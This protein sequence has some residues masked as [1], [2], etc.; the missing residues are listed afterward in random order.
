MLGCKPV[1]VLLTPIRLKGDP[2]DHLI[3]AGRYQGLVGRL[4]YLSLTRPDIAYTIG[5]VSQFIH[6]LTVAHM[7]RVPTKRDTLFFS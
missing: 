3:D 7:E 6:A 4:T 5:V 2:D 1:V